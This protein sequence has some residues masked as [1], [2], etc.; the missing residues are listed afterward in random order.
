MF[1][2][3]SADGHGRFLPLAFMTMLLQTAPWE[4]RC[5][6]SSRLSG[7]HREWSDWVIRSLFLKIFGKRPV[8][9]PEVATP[10]FTASSRHEGSFPVSHSLSVLSA[11]CSQP[12][13]AKGRLLWLPFPEGPDVELLSFAS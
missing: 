9:F 7:V 4:F 5:G 12:V 11:H 8:C 10:C 2:H 6:M 13:C 3:V 1:I